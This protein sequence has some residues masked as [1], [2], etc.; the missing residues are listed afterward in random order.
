MQS[1]AEFDDCLNP[2]FMEGAY[3]EDPETLALTGC[4]EFDVESDNPETED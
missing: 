3:D 2:L 4:L 1:P